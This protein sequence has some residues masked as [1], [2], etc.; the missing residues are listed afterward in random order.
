M[1][2]VEA[3]LALL[4]VQIKQEFPNAASFGK[5]CFRCSPKCLNAIDVDTAALGKF[6]IAMV[7][8]EVLLKAGIHKAVIARPAVG[9]NDRLRINALPDNAL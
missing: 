2:V 4:E 8:S 7:D 9:V 5:S 1:P 6:I 3:E